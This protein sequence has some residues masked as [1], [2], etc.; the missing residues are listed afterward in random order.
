MKIKIILITMILISTTLLPKNQGDKIYNKNFKFYFTKLPDW[1]Y[2]KP[3]KNRLFDI[4]RINTSYKDPQ[5]IK[6]SILPYIN[7]RIFLVFKKADES[8]IF[9]YSK[10]IIKSIKY[11]GFMLH[12]KTSKTENSIGVIYALLSYKLPPGAKENN[13]W[14]S[15]RFFR[16]KTHYFYFCGATHS[17]RELSGIDTMFRTIKFKP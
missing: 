8:S 11:Q 3:K 1:H 12:I 4:I 16:T 13:L 2:L 7:S 6:K 5:K 17:K 10:K 15:L 9:D 14:I